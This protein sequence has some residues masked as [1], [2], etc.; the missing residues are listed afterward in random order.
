MRNNT[1]DAIATPSSSSP[2]PSA[3]RPFLIW[4]TKRLRQ[5]FL[6]PMAIA[7]ISIIFVLS[8][9]F[10]QHISHGLQGN[11]IRIQ[12]SAQNFYKESVRSDTR[13]LQTIMYT[14]LDNDELANLLAQGNRDA[15]LQY[16]KPL[17]DNFRREFNI[18]HLYFTRTD[19]VNLLRVHA[20]QRYGD[21]ITRITMLQAENTGRASHGIELGP[22]GTFTLR[23]VAPWHNKKTG[24][25][26]G[27]IELGMEIDQVVDKLQNYFGVK[28]ITLINKA[29]LNRDKWITGMHSLGR[30]SNWDRFPNEVASMQSIQHLPTA[31]I[32]RLT[33][34]Y[35]TKNDNIIE[36]LQENLSY[37][38]TILPLDDAGG[39]S[40]AKMILITDSSD[41]N[42]AL[43]ITYTG[44]LTMLFMGGT[45][46]VFFYWLIGKIGQRIEDN[47]RKLQK[48]ATRDGLTGLYNH[49]TF[50]RLMNNEITRAQRYQHPVSL[51]MLDI[52]HFKHVNDT[53]GHQAGDEILKGLSRRLEKRMRSTDDVCRYGGEEM[54]VILPETDTATAQKIAIDLCKL[55]EQKAFD[56]GGDQ[57]INITVSIGLATY[58]KHAEEIAM[59]VTGADTALY[60]AKESG[61]NRVCV[62]QD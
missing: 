43:K 6:I 7:L 20:P 41:E 1:T 23:L 15:L 19:R 38:M 49:R 60:Q 55:I 29:F 4:G 32:E 13:A 40:V 47:E 46:F 16:S 5:L 36:L 59:L 62:Y 48:L 53:Y 42:L 8:I 10:Y 58:P 21:L 18:T 27:Y 34:G 3:S 24:E 14:L 37:R 52:D 56:T 30:T 11:S 33:N 28:A 25:L 44:T 12:T 35:T 31:L 51:L 39:R 54:A 57:Y 26:I 2:N 17:L 9:M 22:L 61:R 45:L 50:Y